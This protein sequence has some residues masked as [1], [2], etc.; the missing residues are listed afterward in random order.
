M[1]ID[2]R[3]VLLKLT[4]LYVFSASFLKIWEVLFDSDTI[5]KPFRIVA[6]LMV[7]VGFFY[8]FN[9]WRFFPHRV[10]VLIFA[11]YLWAV[12]LTIFRFLLGCNVNLGG[13]SNDTIQITLNLLFFITAK[14]LNLTEKEVYNVLVAFIIGVCINNWMVIQD[15]FITSI[16]SRTDGL[17]DSSNWASYVNSCTIIFTIY[18]IGQLKNKLLNWRFW[19]YGLLI[20]YLIMGIIASGSR[21][22]LLIFVLY[23][24]LMLLLSTS[25]YDKLRT[26]FY[27]GLLIP[28]LM[29]Y[30]PIRNFANVTVLNAIMDNSAVNR[31]D[32]ASDDIR[33][34][35]WE[36]GWLA[37]LDTW[38]TGLGIGQYRTLK[39]YKKYMLQVKPDFYY[40]RAA[41]ASQGINLHSLYVQIAVDWGLVPLAM[42]A[43]YYVSI[44]R[45]R[46]N[47]YLRSRDKGW[48]LVL[49]LIG[50]GYFTF[51]LTS[52]SMLD[53]GF[54]VVLFLIS[55]Q[56]P[57]DRPEETSTKEAVPA[58][59]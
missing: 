11:M 54:W 14:R 24:P 42:L 33:V 43:F 28:L 16:S 38:G 58:A 59:N 36:S 27:I 19:G 41:L 4:Y 22:G 30:T 8:Q 52:F 35:L 7:I 50:L 39:N 55:S 32:A 45:I 23:V 21:I 9:R 48:P 15:Y 57:V 6:L 13:F 46:I 47:Y 12:L 25:L 2:L 10:D 34:Y 44:L 31:L 1:S 56:I 20:I 5:F 3:N 17:L 51:N 37:I 29:L 40:G 49:L 26:M 53:G 18:K